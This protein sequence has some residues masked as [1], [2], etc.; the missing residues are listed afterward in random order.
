MSLWTVY[1]VEDGRGDVELV[2]EAERAER[3]SRAGMRV[4]ALSEVI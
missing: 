4:T 1:R 3:L 2:T